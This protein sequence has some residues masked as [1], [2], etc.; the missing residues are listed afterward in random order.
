[1][2]PKRNRQ[3]AGGTRDAE[4]LFAWRNIS[5]VLAAVALRGDAQ[6][7]P[8]ACMGYCARGVAAQPDTWS[9]HLLQGQ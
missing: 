4:D 5:T 2:T 3:Q 9:V 6:A 1:M 7:V 8:I